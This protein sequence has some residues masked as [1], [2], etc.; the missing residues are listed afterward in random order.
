METNQKVNEVLNDLIRINHDRSEGYE[1]AIHQL[2]ENDNDLKVL[3]RRY[4]SESREYASVL[5]AEV[6]SNGGKPA[7]S[8]TVSGKIYRAWMEVK[9]AMS[10]NESHSV[11]ESCEFGEDAAQKAYKEALVSGAKM[12][13]G[14]KDIVRRQKANLQLAHDEIKRERDLHAAH[15]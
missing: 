13:A 6:V 3:F 4:A 8:T 11:L 9:S 14:I 15:H 10:N 12:S 1:K 2:T 7:D 5:S